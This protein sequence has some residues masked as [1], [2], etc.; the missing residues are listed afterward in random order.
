MNNREAN[1]RTVAWVHQEVARLHR[2]GDWEGSPR[3]T[4]LLAHWKVHSPKMYHRWKALGLVE[5]LAFVLDMKRYQTALMYR[6]AG[7]PY[8]DSQEQAIRD[9]CLMEPE[10]EEHRD[11]E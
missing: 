10:A 9:R 8:P 3:E 7:M 11:T 4:D 6:R 5:K 2:E 1:P